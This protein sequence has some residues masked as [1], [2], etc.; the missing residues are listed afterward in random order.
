MPPTYFLGLL[1]LEILAAFLFP[2]GTIGSVPL[3]FA[4][5]LLILFG[6]IMNLWS[7]SLFSRRKTAISP[8]GTPT[9]LVVDGPFRISRNP[10]YL[11]MLAILAGAAV[12]SGTLSTFLFPAVFFLIVATTFIPMEEKKMVSIFGNEYLAYE[13]RVRR[14]I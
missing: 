4:G 5:V 6:I 2:V 3:A 13:S 10:I 7:S 9:S 8:L 14:W 1:I 11:G 12:L